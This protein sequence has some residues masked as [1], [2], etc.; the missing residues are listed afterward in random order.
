M[1]KVGGALIRK[2][3]GSVCSNN[4]MEVMAIRS[5]A[6]VT[7]ARKVLPASVKLNCD[8][9]RLKSAVPNQVSRLATCLLTAPWVTKS[10]LAALVKL[11]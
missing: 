2:A 6:G 11:I 1:V 5:N 8:C 9:A 4:C 3:V 10:S 7:A